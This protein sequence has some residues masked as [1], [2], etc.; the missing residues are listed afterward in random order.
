MTVKSRLRVHVRSLKVV[1][2]GWLGGFVLDLLYGTIDWKR[3][4]FKDPAK[5]DLSKP[6]IAA[7]WHGRQLLLGPLFHHAKLP[8]NVTMLISAHSDGRIIARAA[9]RFGIEASTGSSSKGGV[10]AFKGLLQAIERGD[11]VGITP[12]GPRGPRQLCKDGV[13]KLAQMSGAAI[14]PVSV[15]ATKFWR[16]N[17]WDQMILPKPFAK[18][19]CVV[20][21]PISVSKSA[22]ELELNVAKLKL[23]DALNRL[24][25]I[26]DSYA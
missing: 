16:F 1:L 22:G 26:V 24:G 17:S 23:T 15:G 18:G 8:V 9:K 12:D 21:D 20:G 3:N 13:I 11:C 7:F 6:V 10:R 5:L 14:V 25:E 2:G 4:D 19:V